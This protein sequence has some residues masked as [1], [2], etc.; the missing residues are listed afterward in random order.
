MVQV[1]LCRE[2]KPFPS[3][4]PRLLAETLQTRLTKEQINKRKTSKNLSVHALHTYTG[5][6]S[7]E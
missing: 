2:G 4:H 7:D 5:A 1:V 3:T 6:V